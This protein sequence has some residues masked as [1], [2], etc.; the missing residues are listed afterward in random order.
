MSIFLKRRKRMMTLVLPAFFQS[1]QLLFSHLFPNRDE[2]TALRFHRKVSKL[3]G[4]SVLFSL[5][6]GLTKIK[7]PPFAA[8]SALGHGFEPA[9]RCWLKIDP[10]E[11]AVDAGNI[12]LVGRDHLGLENH[13]ATSLLTCLN[14]L[15][16]EDDS[17]LKMGSPQEWFLELQEH[18]G[19]VTTPL[20]KAIASDIKAFLPTGERSRYWNKLMTEFQML[21]FQHETNGSR[22]H[23]GKPVI[24]SVWVWGE[25]YLTQRYP[26]VKYSAIWHDNALVS[27][28]LRLANTN[29]PMVAKTDS[30]SLEAIQDPGRYLLIANQY[31]LGWPKLQLYFLG[32]MNK[33][34]KG[35]IQELSVFIGNGDQYTFARST[36]KNRNEKS[37]NKKAC[38]G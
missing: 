3:S 35:D 5:L 13:E 29:L 36:R 9:K 33:L 25:G 2:Q 7:S 6:T 22:Q 38:F 15:L 11:L 12:C 30:F 28:L 17:Q 10:V 24:N 18:P 26:I 14:H 23:A 8:I 32:L 31:E 37:N 27:G 34:L 19:I 16:Q 1:E 4:E 21:F 20:S